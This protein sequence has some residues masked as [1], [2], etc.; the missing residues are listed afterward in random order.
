MTNSFCKKLYFNTKEEHSQI[1]KHPFTELIKTNKEAGNLYINFN[2]ICIYQI[3]KC[4]QHSTLQTKLYKTFNLPELYISD[5]LSKLIVLCNKYPLEHQYMFILGLISGGN[6]LKKYIDE[7]H[8]EFLTF[9]NPHEL[10]KEFKLYL[11]N[12]IIT[13]TQQETFI[14]IVKESYKLIK[15][16]FDKFYSKFKNNYIYNFEQEIEN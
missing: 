14:N 7:K 3:Q 16:I 4:N 1:D 8:H 6:I 11:D 2:K 10:T 15:L 5:N 9:E 12:L 13:D